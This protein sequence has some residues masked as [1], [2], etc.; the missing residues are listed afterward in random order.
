[1]LKF[2]FLIHLF[3]FC[4]FSLFSFDRT[5][6]DSAEGKLNIVKSGTDSDDLDD[7]DSDDDGSPSTAENSNLR[8][9]KTTVDTVRPGTPATSGDWKTSTTQISA[10]DAEKK[11]ILTKEGLSSVK[12]AEEKNNGY[13]VKQLSRILLSHPIPE[14]RTE[15]ARALGRMGKGIKSLHKAIDTDGY[16]VR[17]S[18]YRAIERIGSRMSLKYFVSGTKSTDADIRL[19]SY[20]GIGKTK[21]SIGRDLILRSGIE[22]GEPAIA[23]AALAGLGY[24]SRKE[25]LD[26]FRRYLSS[27]VQDHRLGAISGLGN[28]KHPNSLDILLTAL[29]EFPNLEPE[30]IFAIMQKK[31]LASTLALIKIYHG[32]RNENHQALIQKELNSRKA[33]GK[34]AIVK[35]STATMKRYSKANSEKVAVLFSSDAARIRKVTDK[36][37]RA[38]MNGQIIEDKYYLVQAYA[39][40]KDFQKRTLVEGW[41]FGPKL[42]IINL[43]SPTNHKVDYQENYEEDSEDER[44]YGPSDVKEPPVKPVGTETA[45]PAKNTTVTPP[46]KNTTVTTPPGKET[47]APPAKDDYYDEDEDE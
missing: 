19:S 16:E 17:Q 29:K 18:A 8:G 22:S 14:V 43:N 21:S 30:I 10:M 47:T 9:A 23:A 32:T 6:K 36:L 44:V 46:A 4:S 25:D 13:S 37:F 38:K 12:L 35:T 26:I 45:P 34:Y 24:Y 42:Q 33:F 20:K 5:P 39:V 7:D 31:T 41:V 3:L 27:E 40:S 2:F 11:R 1:M 28:S 15:A